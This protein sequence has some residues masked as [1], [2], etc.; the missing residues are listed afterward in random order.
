[1]QVEDL[2]ELVHKLKDKRHQL[3]SD[4]ADGKLTWDVYDREC[5]MVNNQIDMLESSIIS[6]ENIDDLI[7]GG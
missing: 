4:F 3:H 1:M 7:S 5:T 2:K 6:M